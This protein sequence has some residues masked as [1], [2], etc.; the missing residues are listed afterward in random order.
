MRDCYKFVIEFQKG[1]W[2][3]GE[4]SFEVLLYTHSM[5]VLRDL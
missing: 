5:D 3:G 2:V 1:C 4:N